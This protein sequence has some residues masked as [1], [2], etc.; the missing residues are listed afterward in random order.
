M[1]DPVR[2]AWCD[3]QCGPLCP[4]KET[5]MSEQITDTVETETA[6]ETAIETPKSCFDLADLCARFAAPDTVGAS[7]VKSLE[8]SIVDLRKKALEARDDIKA[9]GIRT[10]KG[11]QK[12]DDERIKVTTA[13]LD[14]F[15]GLETK[16]TVDPRKHGKAWETFIGTKNGKDCFC[17]NNP[18]LPISAITALRY[19]NEFG[20]GHTAYAAIYPL[21]SDY[22]V[23]LSGMP[24]APLA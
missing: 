8:V 6:T 16:P 20:K 5:A 4:K 24:L 22:N 7:N 3:P 19:V 17:A 13:I 21:L 15:A 1:A 14:Y 18:N 2:V 23:K 9:L 11:G 12:S 10:G